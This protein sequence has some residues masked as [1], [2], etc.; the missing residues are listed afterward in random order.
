MR[1]ILIISLIFV[2][3][4]FS[5]CGSGKTEKIQLILVQVQTAREKVRLSSGNI[6]TILGKSLRVRRSAI[7]LHLKIKEHQILLFHPPQQLAD[8]L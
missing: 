8:A 1:K 6:S 3:L 7:H 5:N 2:A 4:I